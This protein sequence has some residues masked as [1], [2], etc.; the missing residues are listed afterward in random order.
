MIISYLQ[1][2]N[3]GDN[4]FYF[5]AQRWLPVANVTFI[6]QMR[7]YDNF[8]ACKINIYIYIYIYI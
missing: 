4:C 3:E 2:T 7:I 5:K 8:D 6:H 1:I